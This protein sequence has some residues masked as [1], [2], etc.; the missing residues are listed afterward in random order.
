[1][2][3]IFKYCFRL[4]SQ[5]VL[6]FCVFSSI[7]FFLCQWFEES[8]EDPD[9]ISDY[10]ISTKIPNVEDFVWFGDPNPKSEEISF[11]E[12]PIHPLMNMEDS[13][14]FEDYS[15]DQDYD[16]HTT[17]SE[18]KYEQ[19]GPL[20]EA[21]SIKDIPMVDLG[22]LDG[23]DKIQLKGPNQT[24]S[25]QIPLVVTIFRHLAFMNLLE[26]LSNVTTDKLN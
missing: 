12:S 3:G 18:E 1:M 25:T 5:R 7:T 23:L 22:W 8:N 9:P 26:Q 13:V 14:W 2:F 15:Q 16:D 21:I 4:Y 11:E 10:T 20:S 19:T 6:F 24:D 17:S